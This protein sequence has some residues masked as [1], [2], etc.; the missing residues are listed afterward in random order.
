[1]CDECV[2]TIDKPNC[3]CG[4]CKQ[5]API[6][7]ELSDVLSGEDAGIDYLGAK[8]RVRILAILLE[9]KS[10]FAAYYEEHSQ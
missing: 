4:P 2:T 6:Y 5:I 1:M 10:E 3:R 7:K 9:T 8:E